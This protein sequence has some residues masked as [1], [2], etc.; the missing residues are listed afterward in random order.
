[1]NQ[2]LLETELLDYNSIKIQKLIKE[3]K[4]LGLS[5]KEKILYIYNYV[6]D[7]ILFGYNVGDNLSSSV[8]L[9]DGYGQC[10]TKGILFMS[11]LR[12]VG[13]PCRIHGFMIDKVLQKGAITGMAYKLSP[14]EILHSWVE[15]FYDNKW[16]KLE[17]FILDITYLT[18]L[19]EKFE[20]CTGTFCGYGVATDDFK[21]PQV[22]WDENDTYIQKEGIVRDLGV[23][24]SPDELLKEHMQNL[25]FIKKKMYENFVRHLMNKNVNKIRQS[26]M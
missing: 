22:F 21:N 8:I 4:W 17:G 16:L 9:S 5:D 7:E 23:F 10:N 6:R 1:M 12:A 15:V 20:N 11:L 18:R 26:F 19:Q 2:Y 14:N 24:N 25:N 13:I 3:K